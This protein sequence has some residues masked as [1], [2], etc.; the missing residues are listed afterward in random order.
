MVNRLR[1]LLKEL[2]VDT[3]SA[4]I[5]GRLITDNALIALECLHAIK[6]GSN[7]SRRYGVYKFDLTKAYDQVDW[8]YLEG[9]LRRLGFHSTWIWWTMQCVTTVQYSVCFN[10]VSLEPFFPT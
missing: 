10:N 4:F 7:A 6:S 8:D 3:L 9:T 5:H 1:P 2:I